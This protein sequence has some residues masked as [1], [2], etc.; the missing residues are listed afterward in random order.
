[1]N[2]P[3][4]LY[5]QLLPGMCLVWEKNVLELVMESRDELSVWTKLLILGNNS[6]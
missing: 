6:N 1:M 3:K 5:K 2:L 4:L